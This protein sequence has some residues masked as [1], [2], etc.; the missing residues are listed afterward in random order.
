[1]ESVSLFTSDDGALNPGWSRTAALGRLGASTVELPGGHSPFLG[2]P[3]E[4]AEAL[5]SVSL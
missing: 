3:A 5:V 2:R 1:V 4:L